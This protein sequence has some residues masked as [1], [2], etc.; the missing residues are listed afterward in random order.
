[1]ADLAQ[2][3]RALINA[4]KA[5]DTEAATILAKE[6]RKMRYVSAAQPEEKGFGQSFSE[7][8]KDIPRQF[9]LTARAALEGGLGAMGLFT[10]PLASLIGVP[11]AAQ[12]GKTIADKLE[13]PAPSTKMERI[14]NEGAKLLAGG[15]GMLGLANKVSK[16]GG[17]TGEVGKLLAANPAQQLQAAAGAGTA[18]GYV[19][20]TGGDAL[21]TGAA[22]LLGGVAAPMAISG[23]KGVPNVL[24]RGVEFLAPGVTK[25]SAPQ[26][27]II[28]QNVM[29]DSGVRLSDVPNGVLNQ[30][31]DDIAQALK[32]GDLDGQAVK[33][34]V[35]YRLLGATPTRGTLT[36]DPALVTRERNLAKMGMNSS[37]PKLQTLGNVQNANNATLIQRLNEL[38]IN[39]QDGI[40]AAHDVMGKL[41]GMDRGAKA[42]IDDAYKQARGTSGR[43]ANI[44][45]SAFTQRANDLL[46]EELLGGKLPSDVR[47]LLNKAATG[48][49]PLTVDTA[50]QFKTKIFGLQKNTHDLAERKALGLVR[51]ALDDAPLL[52]GQGQQAI[53]AFNNAR[54]LN[55]QWMSVVDRVPALQA[56]RDGIE[57]DKFVDKFIIGSGEKAS[58]MDVAKLKSLI[59]TDKEAMAAVRGQM[60]GY[61]KSQALNGAADEVGN[62]SQSAFNKALA[63]LNERKLRLFF[64]KS[65]IDQIKAIGRVASYEQFQPKGSAVNNS[66]SGALMMAAVF[67]R[68][69]T[70]PV[71][72]K[73]PML[74]QMAGNVSAS[75]GARDALNAAKSLSAPQERQRLAP[76][77]LPAAASIGLLGS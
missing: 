31:K 20:E 42:V 53:D 17:I 2:L 50:E 62:F 3:E 36:L 68:L 72:G 22:A 48:E 75:L 71:L 49:M 57:P 55:R 44:D 8:V 6:I 58:V 63:R 39:N 28:I 76:Y 32:V 10:D 21:G 37:D 4:D 69:A 35:D 52:D 7:G 26:V 24:K 15:G 13:L 47:N 33:R 27:D 9:G 45:P 60:L 70:L 46:D 34:L 19:Q 67:D 56:I 14:G 1:M 73:I 25:Q 54:S 65:E 12:T 38:G 59:K 43:S 74:P 29:R 61:L 11:N 64:S 51:Q 16:V 30:I 77:L 66:N 5:G 18:G 41:R 23:V 40:S